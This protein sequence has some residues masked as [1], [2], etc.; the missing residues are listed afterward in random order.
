V[1]AERLAD[2]VGDLEREAVRDLDGC[3]ADAM[4]RFQPL[5]TVHADRLVLVAG[6]HDLR[7]R[8]RVE[9]PARA[10]REPAVADAPVLVA[11]WPRRAA[12]VDAEE[13]VA[14][15]LGIHDVAV[16]LDDERVRRLDVRAETLQHQ[17]RIVVARRERLDAPELDR[18]GQPGRPIRSIGQPRAR[19]R[20]GSARTS[21]RAPGRRARD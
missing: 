10:Q 2:R 14:P 17:S 11:P 12:V 13:R 5:A 21:A 18:I 20:S 3:E 1:E 7:R 8:E 15:G 6:E 19:A 9:K 16:P 4:R